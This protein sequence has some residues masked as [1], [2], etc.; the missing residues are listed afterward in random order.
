MI[1]PLTVTVGDDPDSLNRYWVF[2]LE[3]S[4]FIII[5]GNNQ[6]PTTLRGC[7]GVKYWWGPLLVHPN[8]PKKPTILYRYHGF[9]M[10]LVLVPTTTSPFLNWKTLSYHETQVMEFTFRACQSVVRWKCCIRDNG[11]PKN[12]L[13][14]I[15]LAFVLI[16]LKFNC[17]LTTGL[18]RFNP[19]MSE[20]KEIVSLWV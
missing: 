18:L 2:L 19:T 5:L 11:Q 8:V 3:L 10:G 17:I 16:I 20:T 7:F 6:V 12:Q 15:S 14:R 9:Y 4:C 13:H 1:G